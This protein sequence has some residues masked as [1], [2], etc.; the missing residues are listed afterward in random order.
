MMCYAPKFIFDL[1]ESSRSSSDSRVRPVEL[2]GNLPAGQ[3]QSGSARCAQ[4]RATQFGPSTFRAL[5]AWE[6]LGASGGAPATD[7]A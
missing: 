5:V 2:V 6:R 3:R 1:V 4:A 7:P